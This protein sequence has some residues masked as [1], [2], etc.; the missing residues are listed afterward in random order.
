MAFQKSPPELIDRFARVLPNH[1]DLQPKK[2]FGYPAA[3]V[4]G[5]FFIGL[6]E[7]RIVVRL[8]GDLKNHFPVL[9]DAGFFDPMGTGKGMKDW[10][11]LPSEITASD[12]ALAAFVEAAFVHVLEL[13]AKEPKPRKTP[14]KNAK[15]S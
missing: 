9:G 13:P 5:N 14:K 1:P 12:D 10:W 3:F 15:G 4:K 6:Y 7:D 2:M 11:A 8:P